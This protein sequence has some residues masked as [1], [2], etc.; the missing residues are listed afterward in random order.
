MK[1]K[2]EHEAEF[3]FYAELN[4]FLPAH[5][6]R[7]VVRYAF[8]GHPAIKDPIEAL[9]V[10]H[11]EVDLIVVNDRSVGFDYRLQ[12]GD[13]VAVYPVFEAIDISPVVRLRPAPLRRT[14]FILDVHLGKLARLLR[15]LGF[16][17]L[18]RND[19]DDDEIVR[20]ARTD[21]RIVLTRDRRLL[22]SG[23]VTHGRWI[24]STDGREQ[25]REVLERFNLFGCLHLFLRCPDCNG[26]LAP[27]EK[28]DI[29]DRLELLTNKYYDEFVQCTDCGKIYWQGSHHEC[30]AEK[31][32]S[33]LRRNPANLD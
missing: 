29:A 27:V 24:H 11:T 18:Y 32:S 25:A 23:A 3:R 14:A 1:V 8:N 19:Y 28:L 12:A 9:G 22:Y 26:L 17:T 21:H 7:Q 15:V 13:R 20:I 16:D 4:D 31:I 5:H 33:I 2:E 6:R 10:P 30:L